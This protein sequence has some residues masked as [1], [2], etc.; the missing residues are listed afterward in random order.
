MSTFDYQPS[1]HVPFRDKA[2]LDRVRKIKREDMEKHPNPDFKI[3]V[4][5]DDMVEHIWVSDMFH[6]IKTAAD[7]GRPV[8]MILPNPCPSYRKVAH[9]INLFGV[10]CDKLTCFAMDEYA[11]QDGHIAPP[12]WR[13]SFTYAMK[14]NFLFL[15]DEHLRPAEKQ[16]VGFTD[17]NID[18]FSQLILDAG[19]ADICYSGPGW[20]GH[21]AFIEP[22]APEFQAPLDEW[23]KM[24]ARVCTLSPYTLAQNS[25]HGSFGMSGD[26]ASVPP[27]AGT[28]GPADVIAAKNRIDFSTLLVHGTATTWQRMM[29]RLCTHGPVTPLLPTSILQEL[30]VDKYISET[31][32]RNVEPDWEKGY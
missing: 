1:H 19:G 18:H 7:E 12:D 20:T 28:I 6:R 17:K 26:L 5:P 16:F 29:T 21:L 10:P 3:R 22:D 32:A 31:L 4:I 2:V 25:L 23:R 27:K 9:L 11:D 15:I 13:P 8:V 30:R 14:H 24:G